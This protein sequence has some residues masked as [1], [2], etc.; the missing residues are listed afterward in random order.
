MSEEPE[1]I[2]NGINIGPG[3]AMTIRVSIEALS[4]DLIEN[5]LGNDEHGKKM[6]KLYLDRI[7]DIRKIMGLHK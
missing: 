4:S 2:I 5:G 7:N 1:I 3:C 6:K